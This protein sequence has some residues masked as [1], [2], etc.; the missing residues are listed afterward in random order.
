MGLGDSMDD[1]KV[2]LQVIDRYSML[3]TFMLYSF[4]LY[5]SISHMISDTVYISLQAVVYTRAVEKYTQ[6]LLIVRIM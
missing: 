4:M 2:G 6:T 3:Y 5:S 1:V